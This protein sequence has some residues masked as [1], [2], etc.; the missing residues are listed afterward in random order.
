MIYCMSD[1][2]GHYDKYLE[3]LRKIDFK[4]SDT[5]FVLGDVVDRGPSSM[6]ILLDMMCRPNVIPILGNH[7]YAAMANLQFLAQ[8]IT[9]D[10][11]SHFDEN[12]MNNLLQWQS[13]GG[14]S[15]MESFRKLDREQ[16]EE[17]LEYLEEFSLYEEIVVGKKKY[18]LV[19]AG[20]KNFNP[21][22]PLWDYELYEVIFDRADYGKTYFDNKTL[23]TGH[24]PTALIPEHD[25]TDT[26]YKGCGHIAIDCGCE[27]DGKLACIR[28][29][30][31]KEFY[32]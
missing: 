14:T 31:E 18:V 10:S 11:L 12:V 22:R 29:N 13:I 16:K 5:L 30:D 25:G 32:V 20:L 9:E 4:D 23:V 26:I 1:I 15:T 19:H 8:E 6:E 2:H 3:M 27:F 17:I 28:L 24:T 7:E 21:D